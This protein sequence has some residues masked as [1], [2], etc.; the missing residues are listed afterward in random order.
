MRGDFE[1]TVLQEPWITV[2]EKAGCRIV[3]STF[4]HGTWV[5]DPSLEP[6]RLR[7]VPARRH[8]RGPAHQCRQAPVR[9]LLHPRFPRPSRRR[10]RSRPEDF[11][12]G[13]IQL[14][15]P[16]PIPEHEARWAWEWMASW[17]LMPGAFDATA[18]IN[19]RVERKAHELAA[20]GLGG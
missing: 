14:K 8:A 17:G 20:A 11:N 5:A 10:R 7:R 13:R 1:A 18:Q 16:G 9:V 2:A 15:E 12:L 4:F 3:S 6:G 19:R